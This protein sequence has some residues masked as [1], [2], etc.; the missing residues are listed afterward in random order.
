MGPHYPHTFLELLREC[1]FLIFFLPGRNGHECEFPPEP[2]KSLVLKGSL[3]LVPFGIWRGS[4]GFLLYIQW[5][6]S[7][8]GAHLWGWRCLFFFRLGVLISISNSWMCWFSWEI[9]CGGLNAPGASLRRYGA[10]VMVVSCFLYRKMQ[11]IA[12][13]VFP[14]HHM[15]PRFLRGLRWRKGCDHNFWNWFSTVQI[16]Q[17]HYEK[18]KSLP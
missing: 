2:W 13:Q 17:V 7:A 1:N 4:K 8:V 12:V 6:I 3:L 14:R 15:Y 16:F 11:R 5:Q 9:I 10:P 18:T